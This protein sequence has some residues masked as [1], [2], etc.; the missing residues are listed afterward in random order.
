MIR[1]GRKRHSSRWL[2]RIQWLLLAVIALAV[3][4]VRLGLLHYLTAF[5]VFKYAGLA[6]VAVALG[7]ILVFIW[8]LVTRHPEARRAALWATILGAIPVAIPLLLVG[9][10]NFRAPAIHDI[11]TDMKEPPAFEAILSLRG[12]GDNSAEYAGE[13][14]ASQQRNSPLYE[15]IQPLQLNLSVPEATELA[16]EVAQKLGWRVVAKSPNKGRLEAVARTPVL[17]FTEDVVVRVQKEGQ[18]VKVDVR[19]A[20]RARAADLGSNGQRIRVFLKKM[21]KRAERQ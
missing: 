2:Y 9:E 10:H 21:K 13:A 15:D 20:S 14:V 11:S 1:S 5:E 7:S 16:A 18:G 3:A 12:P 4:A 8:G 19:S 17:G 6:A